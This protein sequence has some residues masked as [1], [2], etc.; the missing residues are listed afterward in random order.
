MNLENDIYFLQQRMYDD[1]RT[2][3]IE[4]SSTRNYK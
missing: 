1:H 2:L 4:E 3:L